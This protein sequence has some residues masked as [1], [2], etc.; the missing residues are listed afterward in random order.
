MADRVRFRPFTGDTS[1]SIRLRS[2]PL[3]LVLSQVRWPD[4][5]HLQSN[6]KATALNFGSALSEYP[7]YDEMQEVGY[8]IT[9]DGV[10]QSIGDTLYRWASVDRTWH[11]ILGRRF[12]SLYSTS[13]VAFDEFSE[14]MSRVLESVTT[15]VR[16]PLIERVGVRY[17]NRLDDP[18][19]ISRLSEYVRPE[20][21]GYLSLDPASSD[22]KIVNSANQVRYAIDDV[23]LQVRSGILPPN[24]TADPAIPPVP[25]TSWVL[26]LDASSEQFEPFDTQTILA[27]AGRL[28]DVAYDYFKLVTTDGFLR[29]FGGRD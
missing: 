21:L 12:V 22:V 16:A 19:L 7:I 6:L 8:Q 26:D 20:V 28:S 18:R 15:H 5:A 27:C 9:P 1:K 4:L 14:R 2:N 24:E 25:E 17:V 11:V 3:A 13:Y 29:E 10:H 23:N